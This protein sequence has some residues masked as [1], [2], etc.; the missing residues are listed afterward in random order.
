MKIG[1][2]KTI[3]IIQ[4]LLG[5]VLLTREIYHLIIL[6]SGKEDI[7]GGLVTL[8]KYKENTHS[9]IFLWTILL[10]TGLSF[11]INKRYH[12]ALNHISMILISGIII[13]PV[14]IKNMIFIDPRELYIFITVFII[15]L[16]SIIVLYKSKTATKLVISLKDRIIAIVLG[17]LCLTVYM[18]LNIF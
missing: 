10:I 5:T 17:I 14:L 3:S 16:T 2:S 8:Y 13:I 6:P 12:W 18:K 15:S 4:I 9:N 1:R 7:L 11:L